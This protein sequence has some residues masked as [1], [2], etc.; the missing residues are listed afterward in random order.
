[1]NNNDFNKL[2]D[3]LKKDIKTHVLGS[4]DGLHETQ[5]HNM[6][7]YTVDYLH[8]K[9]LLMVWNEDMS[10][11]PYGE[12]HLVLYDYGDVEKLVLYADTDYFRQ[13]CDESLMVTK[14][15]AIAFM[16]LPKGDA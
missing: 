3:D 9:G 13:A 6:I 5:L 16:K 1:M 4:H 7:H 12:A 10:Q 8:A 2:F 11:M 15:G 14:R